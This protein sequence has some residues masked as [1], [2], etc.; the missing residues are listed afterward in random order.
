MFFFFFVFFF[1]IDQFEFRNDILDEILE[2]HVFFPIRREQQ[3]FHCVIDR[4]GF[5]ELCRHFESCKIRGDADRR[6]QQLDAVTFFDDASNSRFWNHRYVKEVLEADF[7]PKKGKPYFRVGYCPVILDGEFAVARSF[8][9]PG[10]KKTPEFEAI[11]FS[12]LPF[13]E[14]QRLKDMA[15]N[16]M[17]LQRLIESGDFSAVRCFQRSG[18]AQVIQTTEEWYH[19]YEL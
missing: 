2:V 4:N 19:S 3:Q 9:P 14:K 16:E 17:T 13:A 1:R 18:V 10:F 12:N 7:D 5:F 15:T 8:L 11:R 6:D